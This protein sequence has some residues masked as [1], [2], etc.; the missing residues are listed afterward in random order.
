MIANTGSNTANSGGGEVAVALN[1]EHAHVLAR[2]GMRRADVQAELHRLAVFHPP[3]NNSDVIRALRRPDDVVMFVAG[4]SGLY[5]AVFPS[6]AAD[7]HRNPVVH[8]PVVTGESC[9]LPWAP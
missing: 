8:E 4:G 3:G 6:W 5:S 7:L 2:A 1:P 9:D